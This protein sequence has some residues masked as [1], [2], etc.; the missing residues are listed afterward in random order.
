MT[1]LKFKIEVIFLCCRGLEWTPRPVA[2]CDNFVG[3]RGGFTRGYRV[4]AKMDARKRKV[5]KGAVLKAGDKTGE[6]WRRYRCDLP[7]RGCRA[8][9]ELVHLC[10][11]RWIE[12]QFAVV[13]VGDDD[14]HGADE[15]WACIRD[16]SGGKGRAECD[17]GRLRVLVQLVTAKC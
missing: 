9:D 13:E 2:L 12:S 14:V 4:Y 15:C 7:C 17:A 3:R 6:S 1:A 16:A 11:C 10:E 8:G 5:G